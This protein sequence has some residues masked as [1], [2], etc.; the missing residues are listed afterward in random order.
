MDRLELKGL[1]CPQ[2]VLAT[3]AYL[4]NHTEATA[5][6]V[7]VDNLPS[8]ENVLRFLESRGF[9]AGIFRKENEIEVRANRDEAKQN[10]S[11]A[12]EISPEDGSKILVVITAD[13]IGSGDDIL[14][15]KLMLNFLKTLHELGDSLWRI[16][17][18]NSGIKLTIEGAESLAALQHLQAQGV[19][20]LVCGTCLDHY[21]LLE[22]KKVGDT[23]NMLDVVLS[24]QIAEK[25]ITI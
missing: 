9:Q 18:L 22:Q 13:T 19:S 17:F 15:S 14:G 7:V 12:A 25:I 11:P 24:H 1:S 5:V 2:P 23:T 4:D 8:A 20:L 10:A 6:C 21:G 3:K 16:I